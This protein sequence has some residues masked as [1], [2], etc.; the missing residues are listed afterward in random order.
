MTRAAA[1]LLLRV[2]A[3]ALAPPVS[4]EY[5]TAGGVILGELCRA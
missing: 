3:F 4:C 5:A 1:L 2:F